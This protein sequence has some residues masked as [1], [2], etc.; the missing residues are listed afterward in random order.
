MTMAATIRLATPLI[1]T[2]L[3]GTFADRANIFNIGLESFMLV[4]SFFAMLGSYLF[5]NPYMGLLFGI[6]SSVVMSII[7][8]ILVLHFGSNA[9]VVGIALNLGAWGLTTLL[10]DSI[11]HVRGA[12][13]DPRIASFPQIHI[14]V[15][16]R[17][18]YVGAILSGQN[19]LV[20]LAYVSVILCWIVMYKTPFGLRVRGVGLNEQAAQTAGV[21]ISKYRWIATIITGVFSGIAGTFLSLG[22]ISMFTEN[23]SAGKGFLAL[24]AIMIGKGNPAHV[25]LACLVFAYSDAVSVGLQSYNIPSQVVLML[26]YIVT[27]IILTIVGV[28]DRRKI[29]KGFSITV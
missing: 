22:G 6:A 18:P 23:M 27:V 16:E 14:P 26:P 3:G 10:L 28:T 13:I 29:A 1:L 17:I 21:S 11:F 20:Y 9:M 8:G 25:F 24:A 5:Q 19:L 2:A 15:L 12:F 4:S 7:F